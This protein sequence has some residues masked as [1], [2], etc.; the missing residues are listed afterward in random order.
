MKKL[1]LL[2]L[3]LAALL[4]L[5]SCTVYPDRHC[6]AHGHYEIGY[7]NGHHHHGKKHKK[8]KKHKK[9]RKHKHHKHHKHHHD[10]D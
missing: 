6:P 2:I 8:H 9:E 4:A 5:G 3:S 1:K 7:H 10:D